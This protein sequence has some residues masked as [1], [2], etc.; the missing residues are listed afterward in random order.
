MFILIILTVLINANSQPRIA[1]V[2]YPPNWW[3]GMSYNRVLVIIQSTGINGGSASIS[4]PGVRILKQYS[5]LGR[6]SN[7][8]FLD[9]EISESAEAGNVSITI[10]SGGRTLTHNFP[11]LK[12]IHRNNF[13]TL[14]GSDV[15]YQIIPDRFSNGNPSNDN[16]SGFFEQADRTNPSGIHGGDILGI[17]KNVNYIA[18]TGVTTV[19]LTPI[20]ESNQLVQSYDKFSP[21][22]HYSID[23]R[24]GSFEDLSLMVSSFQTRQM[25]VI[26]TKI[27]HKIGDQHPFVRNVPLQDW[28]YRR[29]D[30][31]FSLVTNN[32]LFADPYSSQE[33]LEKHHSF[34]DSFDTPS[35]NHNL[36]EVRRYLIQH[37]IWWI[38]NTGVDGIKIED[39]Q[40]N[41]QLLVKELCEEVRKEYPSIILIGAPKTDIVVHNHFWKNALTQSPMFT[42]VTDLPL[43]KRYEN[44]FAEYVNYNESLRELYKII[45]SDMIYDDPAN[46]LITIGDAHNLTRLFTLAE[47]DLSLFKMYVG[48]LLTA[49]GI[50][51]FLYG[52]EVI[53]EGLATGGFGFVR[54]DFPGGW[55]GDKL[56]AFNQTT[57]SPR[58]RDAHLYFLNLLVWRRNNPE[59]MK[60]KTIHFEPNNDLYAFF[61]STEQKKLLVI[62]NNNPNSARRIENNKF[63]ITAGN[64]NKVTNVVTGEVTAGLGNVILNP[65]SILILELTNGN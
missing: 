65:K 13:Q 14:N 40:L 25:K 16:V 44:T 5:G 31:N 46:Q 41:S 59:L 29:P 11:L 61:R 45:A 58:Q 1:T 63:V 36:E 42:H 4:Y 3:T 23:P 54:G 57:L 47:K 18:Q 17:T 34:W 64:F 37:I 53:M 26:L 33:D 28:I 22:N 12:K 43:Y 7:Y 51:S 21:T 48:F 15:I 30:I 32:V 24:L 20:Y 9:I 6:E 39:L 19:E 27:L 8:I 49:R 55:E 60:S 62:I 38:E 50:P 56:N 35:L 10:N 52:T 2:S